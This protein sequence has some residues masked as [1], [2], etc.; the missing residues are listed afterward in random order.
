MTRPPLRNLHQQLD[1][2]ATQFPERKTFQEFRASAWMAE[3]EAEALEQAD[4]IITPHFQLAS[5]FAQ[6]SKLLDW[7][8][9]DIK[10]RESGS[11]I[12]FP[13]PSLARKGAFEVRDAVKHLD[14][15]V[16]ILSGAVESKDFWSGIQLVSKSDEWLSQ[17]AVVIQPAWIENNPR[18]LLRAL[19]AGLPV[20]ATPECGIGAHPLL[21]LVAAGDAKALRDELQRIL[22]EKRGFTIPLLAAPTL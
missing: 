3:A 19:A 20:I 22:S 12:V 9:P 4:Q 21:T 2:L 11:H 6:K 14:R 10:N 17:A 16:L 18:P 7:K 15:P 1:K 13:G 8:L 5:L